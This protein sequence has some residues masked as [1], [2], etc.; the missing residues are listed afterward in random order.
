VDADRYDVMSVEY[1]IDGGAT[2]TPAASLNP[3]N[4]PAGR[5][6]QS[7]AADGLG[8]PPA[9]H[10]YIADLSPAAGHPDVRLRFTFSTN[11][12]LFNGFR[13]WML[14]NIDVSTP[15]AEPP[16]HIALLAPSCV[17]ENVPTLVS[18][19]GEHFVLG[20]RLLIDGSQVTGATPSDERVE[21]LAA[22]TGGAH[23]V[24]VQ[25]PNGATSNTVSL[26]VSN[27]CGP[28]SGRYVA[29][30]D[31]YSSGEGAPPFMAGTDTSSDQC[32]RSAEA[33]P[34]QLVQRHAGGVIPATVE[35]WACSGSVISDFT[36][37]NHSWGEPPQFGRLVPGDATLVTLGIG[38]NDIGF[39]EVV[40]TCLKVEAAWM[41]QNSKYKAECRNALNKGTM[42]KIANLAVAPLYEEIRKDAPY[43]EV[44]VM[45][46]PRV[47]PANPSSACKAQ[48]YREDGSKATFAGVIGIETEIDEQ[49]AIWL[50]TVI[51]R[52]NGKIAIAA[53]AAGVHY[54]ENTDAFEG[55]DICSNNTDASDR[56]WAHGLVLQNSADN[57]S[58]FSFHPDA[59]GQEAMG[60]ELFSAILGGSHMNVQQG[61]T[62]FFTKLVSAG[63]VLL[64]V[65]THWPGSD[66]VTTL[67]SPSGQEFDRSSTGITHFATATSE[68]YVIPDPEPGQ[69][70]VELYG[71][72][73]HAGGEEAHVDAATVPKEAEAPVAVAR[74]TP[75]RGIVPTEVQFDG[76]ASIGDGEPIASYTWNFGDGTPASSG[77]T[78]SHSYASA[79][80]YHATLTVV[81]A[82]GGSDSVVKAIMVTSSPVAP[83]A[84]INIYTDPLHDNQVYFDGTGSEDVDGEIQSYKWSFGD[85]TQSNEPGGL[86]EYAFNGTY[87]IALT[88]TD[89]HGQLGTVSQVE[90]VTTASPPPSKTEPLSLVNPNPLIPVAPTQPLGGVAGAIHTHFKVVRVMWSRNGTIHL[91]LRAPSAGRFSVIATIE[92]KAGRGRRITATAPYGSA[93]VWSRAKALV[94]LEIKPGQAARASL[95]R[96]RSPSVQLSIVF[97]TPG[98]PSQTQAVRVKLKGH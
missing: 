48:A 77:A 56:P 34:E 14:D 47:L 7:Y 18:A 85:G 72:N 35:F 22:L 63:Q 45:G 67:V 60:E 75:D 17:E 90:T 2:W 76:S 71:A 97:S 31:S 52:L 21:L 55:H 51:E 6:D 79:G 80:T 83:A 95:R 57:P 93:T 84:H 26:E 89:N 44:Y 39:S 62:T 87:T 28:P 94:K 27:A 59:E 54:V 37:N 43:A 33:Y 3:T 41:Q 42:A 68:N 13:G 5:D 4:N 15:F 1:S 38:G 53:A 96:V 88:V 61:Q 12:Q 73:V 16:P 98:L 24:E 19:Y 91:T 50:N 40:E 82:S 58:A 11:D 66:I 10:H 32:H 23:S 49:D 86:H 69:W 64:N 46:Y 20:S 8:E 9:W 25:S 36:S 78:V 29:L 65:I 74:V 70:T 81:D 30:G 92:H